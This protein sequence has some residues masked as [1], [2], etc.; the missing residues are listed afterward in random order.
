[1]NKLM[2]DKNS[3]VRQMLETALTEHGVK[4]RYISNSTGFEYTTLSKFK[5]EKLNYGSDKLATLS[6]FLKQYK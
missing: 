6:S 2:T 4:M 3:E 5:N 1:M